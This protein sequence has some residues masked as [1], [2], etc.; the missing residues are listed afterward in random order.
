LLVAGAICLAGALAGFVATPPSR[1]DDAQPGSAFGSFGLTA[2]AS[3]EQ[4]SWDF[5]GAT[6]HPM[7]ELESPHAVAQL[8]SGPS[9]Y[10]LSAPAWPGTLAGN[11]GTTAQ[12]LGLGLP[13]TVTGNLNDPV[14]A[15]ARTGTEPSTVT[16]TSYPGVMLFATAEDTA[17]EART[18]MA[19]A[20]G[21]KIETHS[22]TEVTGASSGQS[23]AHATYANVNIGGV[24]TIGAASSSATAKI[25][26]TNTTSSGSTVLSG[27]TVAGVPAAIDD[28]GLHI[29]SSTT[30]QTLLVPATNALKAAGMQILVTQPTEQKS[31]SSV[32]Y[33]APSVLFSWKP[34]GDSNGDSFTVLLGGVSAAASGTP[35]FG[36]AAQPTGDAPAGV[37][38]ATSSPEAPGAARAQGPSGDVGSSATAG[39]TSGAVSKGG[40]ALTAAPAVLHLSTAIA[41]LWVVLGLLGVAFVAGAAR[42]VPDQVLREPASTCPLEG[43]R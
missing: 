13:P 2:V 1:A 24:I 39:T 37:D 4:F 34:P 17:V 21:A 10:A 19:G 9:G 42:R 29:G 22:T 38:A 32:A 30:P 5:P 14:R 3:G 6:A 27:V 40:T 28:K 15:E 31:N 8:S 16:N 26:G 36:T 12:L 23:T 33:T 11:A 43:G 41:P 20:G 25:D 7:A 18:S 35:G